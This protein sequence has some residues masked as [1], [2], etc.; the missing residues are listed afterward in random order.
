MARSFYSENKRVSNRAM[1]EDLGVALLCPTYREAC[2]TCWFRRN[3]SPPSRVRC[4]GEILPCRHRVPLAMLA[5]PPNGRR[6][7]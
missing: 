4:A 5:L 6:C 1:R 2:K 3:N 7:K